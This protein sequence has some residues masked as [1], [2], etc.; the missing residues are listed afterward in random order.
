MNQRDLNISEALGAYFAKV[1]SYCEPYGNGY[2]NDTFLVISDKR[3][4]LQRINTSIFT[5]P[6]ELMENIL[7]VTEHIR[8]KVCQVGGDVS[9]CTLV[10][11]P[12]IEGENYFCDSSD[13]Y[14]RLYEFTEGTVTLEQVE[15]VDQFYKCGKA[16]GYFQQMLADYPA[17]TLHEPIANLH[18]TP[19]RYENLMRAVDNDVCGRLSEAM[20]EVQFAKDREAFCSILEESH[21]EGKLPLHVTHN[22]T[23]LN[24]I[25]FDEITGEPV[26]AIDLDTVMPGYAI[27]DFGDSIRSGANTAGDSETDLSKVKLDLELFGAYAKGFLEG[28]NGSL[29]ETEI[30]LLP[31]SAMLITLECGMRFLTD[32]L[33]GDT[34][35]KIHYPDHNLHRA[36][37]QFALLQD[38]ESKLDQMKAMIDDLK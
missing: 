10:V 2:I 25:L 7:G 9:R 33:E 5:R 18:N 34:Y 26:C 29:N 13:H 22:D 28:C 32:Y 1:P 31:V 12:T 35:F 17:N 15:N 4:I 16:F 30:E 6:V 23:K 38:M 21:R 3:Y 24:N 36:R 20:K 14:W 8:N 37:N 27:T 11:L 19:W